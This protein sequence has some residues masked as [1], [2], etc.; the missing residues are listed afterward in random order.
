MGGITHTGVGKSRQA[1]AWVGGK[2]NSLWTALEDGNACLSSSLQTRSNDPKAATTFIQRQAGLSGNNKPH[3]KGDDLDY[4][5]KKIKAEFEDFGMDTIA[6]RRDPN[7]QDSMVCALDLHPRLNQVEMKEESEWV[8]KRF[9]SCD[10]MNDKQARK[11]LLNSLE[12]SS[13]KEINN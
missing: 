12:S 4:F 1:A 6:H 11:F 2:P 7:D 9:D 13:Q 10:E 3:K 5:I 8:A